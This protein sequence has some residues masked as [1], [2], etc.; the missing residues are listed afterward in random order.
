[1]TG[2]ADRRPRRLAYEI[3]RWVDERDAYANLVVAERLK[4]A[5]LE[6]RDA[7]LVTELVY[8]TL[9][10]RGVLDAVL[11]AGS[12]RPIE[13]IDAPVLDVLRLGA[14]QLLFTR[15]PPHAA[16]AE[17]VDLA[18][19][20]VNASVSGFV[21]AVLRRVS[22][23]DLETW[24]AAVAPTYD[25]DPVGHLALVN[26][27]PRWIA[28]AI[29]DALGGD[30]GETAAALAADNERPGVH[31]MARPGETDRDA[32]VAGLGARASVGTYSPYAVHLADGN[33]GDLASVRDHRAQVQ[34]EGS[35][36]AALALARATV[37][38]PESRWLDMAAGPGGK[39]VLLAGLAAERGIDL[40]ASDVAPHRARLVVENLAGRPPGATVISA[41]GRRPAW[42]E[43]AF[44]RVLL[45]APCTGLGALRRRPEARW[46]RQPE[47]VAG[48]VDLQRELLATAI[49]SARPGGAVAYVTCSPHVQETVDVVDWALTETPDLAAVDVR[50][51]LP[52]VTHGGA[53]PWVQLWPHRQG[54]DAMFIA[55]LS[56]GGGH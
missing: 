9:R 15:V 30:L 54:T 45:D 23:R 21:N 34:D 38:G 16:V 5:R 51:L 41:D 36:L 40:L 32:L 6:A 7:A 47:A 55:V 2:S 29:S 49:R 25:T 39:A 12:S 46:R 27:H 4:A 8:G 37:D 20:A 24:L 14:Y 48:L 44:D 35:Q 1:M 18:R 42:R 50:N 52:E 17:T 13:K 22:E 53:G 11:A 31:L 56:V 3:L 33:P 26:S 10:M 28:Q 43:G 19:T